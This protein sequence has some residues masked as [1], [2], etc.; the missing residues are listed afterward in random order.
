M[1]YIDI[2]GNEMTMGNLFAVLGTILV[3]FLGC[4]CLLTS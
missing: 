4:D 2:V 3:Y 1:Q